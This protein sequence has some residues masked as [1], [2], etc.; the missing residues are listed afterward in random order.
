MMTMKMTAMAPV[1]PATVPDFGP[2]DVGERAAAAARRAPEDGHVVHGAGETAAGDQP[3]EAGRPAELRGERRAD[4][5]AR[6]GDGRE[7][8]AE[9]HPAARRIVVVAV[10][11]LVRRRH[12]RVVERH[13][14]G[15]D[16]RAVVA[17]RDAP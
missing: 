4:Q 2:R 7:M 12:A 13:D 11:F 8:M 6:A 10:V 3:D 16:E 1:T 14:L 9:Q 15:G 5:R 17:V